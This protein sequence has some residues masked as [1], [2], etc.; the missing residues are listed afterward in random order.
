MQDSFKSAHE[1]KSDRD[2]VG[3]LSN[4]CFILIYNLVF[5]NKKLLFGNKKNSLKGGKII[6][7]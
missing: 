7:T 4:Y 3:K 6:V 5:E 2:L 1:L